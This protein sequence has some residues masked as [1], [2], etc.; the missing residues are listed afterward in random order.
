MNLG[1][2]SR[3]M[4]IFAILLTFLAIFLTQVDSVQA[5]LDDMHA[6]TVLAR[7]DAEIL[8]KTPMGQY[9]RALLLKH[10]DEL[11]WIMDS[12]PEH[13]EVVLHVIRLFIPDLEV[14]LDGK[15]DKVYI[16]SEHVESAKTELDWFASMGSP[17]LRDDIRKEEQR[18]PL[19][20]FVG[21][22]MSD[23]LKLINSRWTP[24]MAPQQTS[25]PDS[26]VQSAPTPELVIDKTLVP[27]SNGKWAYYVRDGIYFEYPTS[28]YLRLTKGPSIDTIS[29]IPSAG[30]PGKWDPYTITVDILNVPVAEKDRLRSDYWYQAESIIWAKPIQNDTFEGIEFISKPVPNA[31]IFYLDVVQYSQENQLALHISMFVNESLPV[32]GGFDYLAMINQRYEYFQ[33]MVDHLCMQT[34]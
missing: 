22:T 31:S 27:G 13:E 2:R 23:A 4:I 12:H 29:F 21:M 15:G 26:V 28:Y 18:L 9:Y 1:K 10:A 32:S 5:T 17:A 25:A 33:H 30:V 8:Q 6:A 34:P 19:D 11:V 7:V 16:S 3:W 14:L 24:D 20:N